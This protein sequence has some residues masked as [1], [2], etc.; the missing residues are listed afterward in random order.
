MFGNLDEDGPARAGMRQILFW[1]SANVWLLL[2]A[3]LFVNFAIAMLE[4]VVTGVRLVNE[5]D[6]RQGGNRKASD[7]MWA[8]APLG[9]IVL[10]PVAG[11]L[12]DN[13]KSRTWLPVSW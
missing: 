3:N 2:L 10:T 12:A 4:P 13:F 1:K 11:K 8:V 7:K 9:F 6:N 5:L